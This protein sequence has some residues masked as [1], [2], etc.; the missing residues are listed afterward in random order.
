M[1]AH[2]KNLVWHAVDITMVLDGRQKLGQPSS[3]RPLCGMAAGKLYVQL[4]AW[5]HAQSCRRR[6]SLGKCG[7]NH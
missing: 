5:P 6:L 3:C 4:S 1:A 7:R 2:Q